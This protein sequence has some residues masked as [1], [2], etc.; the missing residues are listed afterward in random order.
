MPKRDGSKRENHSPQDSK[1]QDTMDQPI[2]AMAA[3]GAATDGKVSAPE[4]RFLG[5]LLPTFDGLARGGIEPRHFSAY[6]AVP[7]PTAKYLIPHKAKDIWDLV[8]IMLAD[9]AS[10]CT[11]FPG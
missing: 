4:F 8:G 7:V 3:G 6:G 2:A 1:Q 5:Q 9:D 11:I 10:I